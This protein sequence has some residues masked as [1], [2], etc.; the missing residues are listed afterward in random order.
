MGMEPKHEKITIYDVEHINNPC[1]V[2]VRSPGEFAEYH[3]PGAVNIPIFDN[4]ERAE[5]GTLYKQEGREPAK[6]R[7]LQ[8]LSGK[9]PMFYE[10]FR[11]ISETNPDSPIIVYCWRGGM[12]SGAVVSTMKMMELPVIQ[13]EGGI[14]SYRKK[15]VS[16]LEE[17]GKDAKSFVVLEGNTGT[18]KTDILQVLKAE[19]YPVIDLEG[20]ARHRGSIFGSIGLNPS[21]QKEFEANLAAELKRYNESP[22]YLIE[23]ESKRVG[24][25]LLPDFIVEGKEKGIRI[26]VEMPF[27]ERI[28][29]I[30]ETYVRD[31][32]LDEFNEATRKLKKKIKPQ[33]A[34]EE[35]EQKLFQG[36]YR[37]VISVL[38]EYYYDPRYGHASE[39]YD[40][41]AFPV[42]YS[43]LDEGVD[44]VKEALK[45]IASE[46]APG[47]RSMS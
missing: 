47:K 2:D 18:L 15:T 17:A 9:L 6:A 24:P 40:T 5:I 12:R 34:Q 39:G 22:Y 36:D 43:N 10:R 44:R 11:E 33:E 8:V 32:Y 26:Q 23:A 41:P 29:N 45:E 7:G 21:S 42:Y 3:L 1:F 28:S 38:L 31:G 16:E 4:E 37:S 46:F 25:V 35:L 20:L 13:L 14:R 27:A 19:G 30:M